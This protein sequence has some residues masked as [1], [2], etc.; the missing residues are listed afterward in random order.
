MA[1]LKDYAPVKYGN[2]KAK[3]QRDLRELKEEYVVKFDNFMK[4][5]I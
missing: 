2:I 4:N 5:L 1:G 3:K